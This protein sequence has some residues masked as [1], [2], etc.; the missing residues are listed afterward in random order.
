MADPITTTTANLDEKREERKNRPAKSF[1][2]GGEK[3][4][5]R[6]GMRPEALAEFEDAQE[7]ATAF[8]AKLAVIDAFIGKQLEGDGAERWLKLREVGDDDDP[9]TMDDITAVVEFI[10]EADTDR[11][12][13]PPESSSNGHGTTGTTSTDASSSQATLEAQKA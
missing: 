1:I 12:T 13:L 7:K 6:K 4:E 10:T 8:S 3:F 2:I 5:V 11:P 9:L